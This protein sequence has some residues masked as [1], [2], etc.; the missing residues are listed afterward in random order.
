M[1]SALNNRLADLR[2]N[3]KREGEGWEREE[4]GGSGGVE[5]E[6][7][8]GDQFPVLFSLIEVLGNGNFLTSVSPSY[9]LLHKQVSSNFPSDREIISEYL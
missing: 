6:R 1:G 3:G 4:G 7:A 9:P 8:L 2:T 5:V